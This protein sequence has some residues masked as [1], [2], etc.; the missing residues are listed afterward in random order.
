MKK[1]RAVVAEDEVLLLNNLVQKINTSDTGFTV[2]GQAQTGIQALELVRELNPDLLITDIRMPV[3]DGLTLIE[4]VREFNS[5]ID[6]VITS[7]YSDFDYARRALH[8]HVKEYLLKPVDKDELYRVL[9]TL[10]RRYMALSCDISVPGGDS[11]TA[12]TPEQAITFIHEYI[13]GHYNED[14][15]F[16]DLADSIG[17]NPAYLTRLFFQ[18]YGSTP[19]KHLT[20]V[21][22]QKAQQM[23]LRNPELTVQQIGEAVGYFEQGYF[24]RVFKKQTGHSPM[25]YRQKMSSTTL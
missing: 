3:M 24:S 25:S 1:Y 22:I 23:L 14:I 4:K 7:G 13:S 15:N 19:S 21:R 12:S 5:E 9:D 16:T 18:E 8:H 6:I 17:Y 11:V 2:A 10:S 20:L